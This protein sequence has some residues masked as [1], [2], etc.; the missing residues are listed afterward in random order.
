MK[1][2]DTHLPFI[3]YRVTDQDCLSSFLIANA[4]LD[5]ENHLKNFLYTAKPQRDCK[6]A[7]HWPWSRSYKS[8][9][10]RNLRIFVMSSSVCPWQ[11]F[12]T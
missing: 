11:A 5:T 9:Y 6:V 4:P 1:T 8:A 12:P 7:K 10:M 3:P 2:S